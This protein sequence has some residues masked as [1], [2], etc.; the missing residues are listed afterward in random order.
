MVWTPR[1]PLK[2]RLCIQNFFPG[3]FENPSSQVLKW[4]KK[5]SASWAEG[6]LGQGSHLGGNVRRGLGSD[7]EFGPHSCPLIEASGVQEVLSIVLFPSSSKVT[8][9]CV[10]FS[11]NNWG[12]S[13]EAKH[14][15]NSGSSFARG[16][17]HKMFEWRETHLCHWSGIQWCF[18]L[19]MEWMLVFCAWTN[20]FGNPGLE[21]PG[22][23][24]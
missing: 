4:P 18:A 19:K 24:P 17:K 23:V 13:K 16:K 7:L 22:N 9:G 20:L 2:D 6:S 3:H 5:Y 21:I 1:R 10:V 14:G 8:V 12:G 15:G 11:K